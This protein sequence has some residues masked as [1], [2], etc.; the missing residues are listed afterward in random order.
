MMVLRRNPVK[1]A[2]MGN[3]LFKMLFFG[4]EAANS[5]FRALS[6]NVVT[7]SDFMNRNR[8]EE[9]LQQLKDKSL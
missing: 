9:K 7:M 3:K 8:C 5:V 2:R 6:F 4:P 1:R